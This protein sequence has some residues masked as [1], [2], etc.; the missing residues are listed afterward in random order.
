MRLGHQRIYRGIKSPQHHVGTLYALKH[1]AAQRHQDRIKQHSVDRH[2]HRVS[3]T[4][5]HR[6]K[7]HRGGV[8]ADSRHGF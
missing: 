2:F 6:S 7:T 3:A 5:N 8:M 4:P 1:L